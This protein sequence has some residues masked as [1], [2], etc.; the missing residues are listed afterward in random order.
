MYYSCHAVHFLRCPHLTAIYSRVYV[1]VICI[2]LQILYTFC[3]YLIAKRAATLYVTQLI[4][5]MNAY[6]TVRID[7]VGC[8]VHAPE[9]RECGQETSAN[10]LVMCADGQQTL[11]ELRGACGA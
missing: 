3:A 1:R 7:A 4:D 5:E 6:V 11:R 8:P 2:T 10:Y 9:R